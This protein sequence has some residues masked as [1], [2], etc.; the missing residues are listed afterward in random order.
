M[1]DARS[2]GCRERSWP[3]KAAGAGASAIGTRATI[4]KS[5]ERSGAT[6]EVLV[7]SGCAGGGAEQLGP[8]HGA[9]GDSGTST[10]FCD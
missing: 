2:M 8:R 10:G 9:R 5:L 4:P 6:W 3:C 1:F 7:E